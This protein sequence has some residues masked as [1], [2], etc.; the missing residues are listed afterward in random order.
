MP[1]LSNPILKGAHAIFNNITRNVVL[2]SSDMIPIDHQGRIF[3]NELKE[4]L[5]IPIEIKNFYEYT[6]SL[7]SDYSRLKMLTI[8]SACSDVEFL[9]K[10]F[11]E[12]YYDITENKT[13]NFYQRLD[14]VNRNVFIKKGVDLNNE[15]FYKKIKLAFQVRHISIH[16]M[17]FIDEGFNQ[18]TGLNLPINSKF[19]IN[20]IFINES[21]DAIEELI[22]FLDTL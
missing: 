5:G 22:L 11:I 21:F 6:I 3:S 7:G 12:N 8:I 19:E 9:L 16:N 14:D 2:Y 1:E 20:N 10:H 18:K 17:G 13:K 4:A 15:V